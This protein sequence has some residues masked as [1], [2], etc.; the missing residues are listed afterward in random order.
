MCMDCGITIPS[1]EFDFSTS[2]GHNRRS[3]S[4]VDSIVF[5]RFSQES[6]V[7][8]A[9]PADIYAGRLNNKRRCIIDW[10]F[11]VAVCMDVIEQYA[12]LF[13]SSDIGNKLVGVKRRNLRIMIPTCAR[14]SLAQ[15]F[16]RKSYRGYDI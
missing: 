2:K 9:H 10:Y 1:S 11:M 4:D 15:E 7:S 3:V 6:I 12:Y 16:L 13:M 8:Q 14:C 5:F